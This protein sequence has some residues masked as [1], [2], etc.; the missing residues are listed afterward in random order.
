[1]MRKPDL[2]ARD[3]NSDDLQR[4]IEFARL[5]SGRPIPN[6]NIIW[7]CSQQFASILETT[8]DCLWI[9]KYVM[10]LDL[11]GLELRFDEDDEESEAGGDH[12][13]GNEKE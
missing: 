10:G 12:A 7:R 13:N 6:R 4:P 5:P 9:A 2:A 1:M 3:S 11:L 8:L